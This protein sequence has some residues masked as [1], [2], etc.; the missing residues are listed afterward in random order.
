[1]SHQSDVLAARQA[2]DAWAAERGLPPSGGYSG[3]WFVNGYLGGWWPDGWLKWW[4]VYNGAPGSVIGGDIVNHQWTSTPVDR[5]EMLDSEV[6]VPQE[7]PTEPDCDQDWTNKKELVVN[8]LGYIQGDI[9]GR[10]HAEAN[11]RNGPRK[12]VIN[13]IA[14]ELE[15]AASQAL[16]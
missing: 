9:V 8:T 14:D 16:A 2:A 1:M 5:D 4:A 15:R 7:P 12:T 13:Q 6:V 10:L 11:R 3:D